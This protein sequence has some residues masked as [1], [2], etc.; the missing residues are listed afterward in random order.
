MH[1]VLTLRLERLRTRAVLAACTL[2]LHLWIGLKG[3]IP[4]VLK[5]AAFS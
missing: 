3:L 1:L 4:R 2:T 5:P